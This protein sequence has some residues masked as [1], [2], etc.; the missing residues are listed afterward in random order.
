MSKVYIT[1]DGGHNYDAAKCYGDLVYMSHGM[2][3]KFQTTKMLR[4]FFGCLKDSKPDDY[5]LVSG[6]MVANI[7]AAF[8]FAC[9]HKRINLLL[10]KGSSEGQSRYLARSLDLRAMMKENGGTEDD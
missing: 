2:L 3:E 4:L 8:V 9:L 10:W 1:N 7:C 6:P 5:I